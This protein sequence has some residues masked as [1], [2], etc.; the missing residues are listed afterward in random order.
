[1]RGRV[2]FGLTLAALALLSPAAAQ[3]STVAALSAPA[4]AAQCQSVTLDA[5]ASNLDRNAFFSTIAWDT[6]SGFGPATALP[7]GFDLGFPPPPQ[8]MMDSVTFGTPGT[9]TVG[10]RLTDTLG[11]TSTAT[12]TLRVTP[13]TSSSAPVPVPSFAPSTTVAYT[14]QPITFDGSSSYEVFPGAGCS[15][16]PVT[17][18]QLGGYAWDFG[19]G[20]GGIAGAAVMSHAF[21]TAGTYNVI[22]RVASTD[23]AGGQASATHTVSVLQAPAPPPPP[24]PPPPP[25]VALPKG[26]INVDGKGRLSLRV[27]CLATSGV[28]A[29]KLQ[30]TAPKPATKKRKGTRAVVAA[31]SKARQTIV[32]ASARFSI[33]AGKSKTIPMRLS[34]AGRADVRAAARKGLS[35]TLSAQPLAAHAAL[36]PATQAVLLVSTT[37]KPRSRPH[38]RR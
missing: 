7:P 37:P 9:F 22:L 8:D 10:V 17:S 18:G 19:D 16:V 21:A 32:L 26:T 20:A 35:A 33:A 29:G 6:G 14:G 3:A 12:A 5:S 31:T 1:M 11:T 15:P 23:P 2:R 24:P 13:I 34:G 36:A 38:S 25:A 27:R 4:S 28:C 30:L